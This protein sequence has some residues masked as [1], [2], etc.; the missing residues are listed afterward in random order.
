MIETLPRRKFGALGILLL[1]TVGAPWLASQSAYSQ[2]GGSEYGFAGGQVLTWNGEWELDEDLTFTEGGVESVTL[3]QGVSLFSVLSLSNDFNLDEARDIYLDFLLAEVG[4]ATTIDRGSYGSV[5]YSLD[6]VSIDGFDF[7]FFTLFRAGSGGTPTFAYTFFSQIATFSLQFASA[8]DQFRLDDAPIYD[9]V[10][11]AGLQT[12]LEA[13]SGDS[14][15][16]T[17]GDEDQVVDKS[18]DDAPLEAGEDDSSS[19]RGLG[20]LKS[21]GGES[22]G[23]NSLSGSRNTESEAAYVSPQYGVALD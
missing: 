12:Q 19:V 10:D 1:L 2:S 4:G 11:G 8:Q 18:I 5:S 23:D 15:G 3:F 21:G 9:G 13:V 16:T 14:Q 6:F 17:A 7:G 22:S 20:G